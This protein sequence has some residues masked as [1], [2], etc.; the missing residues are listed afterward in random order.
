MRLAT[1]L[2]ASLALALAQAPQAETYKDP[3]G[4]FHLTIPAGWVN[5]KIE[6]RKILTFGAIHQKTETAPFDGLC[7]GMFMDVPNS[8]TRSQEEINDAIS[9]SVNRKFWEDAMKSTDPDFSM[10]INSSGAREQGGR[11]VHYVEYTG[12]GK[13]GGETSSAKGKMEFHFVPGSMHFVMCMAMAEHYAAAS[14]DFTTIFAS[15]EPHR[16]T[17]ISR[18][19]RTAPSV[20]TMFAMPGF[21]GAARV[22]S[23]DTADLA[24]AG[25]PTQSASLAVDGAEPWQ[26]C[27]RAGFTGPCRTIVAAEAG[28]SAAIGSARRMANQPSYAGLVA[29][30]VRRAMQHPASQK[31]L[32]H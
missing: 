12:T 13:K 14:T 2:F 20:L 25:W 31:L 15:Y 11:D 32:T 16:D 6:D 19:E 9:G 26:V 24:A 27:A 28:S 3:D 30:A 5:D 29:T 21:K 7:L 18:I 23:Q 4:R 17:V 8:R 10:T 1:T 22:L